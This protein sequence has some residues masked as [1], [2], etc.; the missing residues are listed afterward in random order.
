MFNFFDNS[1]IIPNRT[2]GLQSFPDG[3]KFIVF[4]P[5]SLNSG[6]VTL[7]NTWTAGQFTWDNLSYI[8]Y[9]K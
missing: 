8:C 9:I 5:V 2:I 6:N 7:T 4:D 3:D 1:A